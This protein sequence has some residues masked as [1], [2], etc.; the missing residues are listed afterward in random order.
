MKKILL[1]AAVCCAMSMMAGEEE[2]RLKAEEETK[3]IKAR[4]N[5]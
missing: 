2:A 1:F 5:A 3:A 4:L